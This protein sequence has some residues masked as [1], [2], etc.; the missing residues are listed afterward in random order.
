MTNENRGR[1]VSAPR[2][3]ATQTCKQTLTNIPTAT[4]KNGVFSSPVCITYTGSVCTSSSTTI[5]P[6]DPT[7]LAYLKDIVNNIPLPNSPTDPQGYIGTARGSNDE[8][9]TYIRIDHQ[10]TS[11]LSVFFRYLDDPFKLLAPN[12]LRQATG[13]PGVSTAR[14]TDG[15]TIFMG[16]ATY[17]FAP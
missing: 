12:G 1:Y 9:Q 15:A 3:P 14:V 17:V 13:I 2:G 11:K 7:T 6:K 10:V 16:H 8:T 5:T 4:Q